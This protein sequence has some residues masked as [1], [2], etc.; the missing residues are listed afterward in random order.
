MNILI[1]SAG[2]R[3]KIIQYFKKEFKNIG[4]VLATE[5]HPDCQINTLPIWMIFSKRAMPI[6]SFNISIPRKSM[7]E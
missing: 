7:L 2:T 5:D 6:F 4:R 1:L 3:N